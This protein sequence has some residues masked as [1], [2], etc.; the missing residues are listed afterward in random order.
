MKK[1]LLIIAAFCTAGLGL[2]AEE[3]APEAKSSYSVTVDFTYG[4]KYVFRGQQLAKDTLF[5]SVELSTGPI[6]AGIWSAQ[7]VVDNIDNEIDFYVGYGAEVGGGWSIDTGV[8]LYYYP[9]LD[10]S[11]GADSSTWEPYVGITGSV[12]GVSPGAYLYYDA[13]LKAL[14]I[15]GQLGYSVALEPA[16]AS[17]DFSA[18]LGRINPDSGSSVTYYSVGVSVPFAISDSGTITVGL[19]YTHN[20]ITGGDGYGKNGNFYGTVG[21]AIGF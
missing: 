14:T 18:N 20:N 17:L 1:T 4:T 11:S 21:V 15:E 12:G 8:C 13:T 3:A 19:N 5:P 10:K 16:G 6:T 9:E 2:R 7:P